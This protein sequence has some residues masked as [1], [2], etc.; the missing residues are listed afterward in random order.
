MLHALEVNDGQGKPEELKNRLGVA[1]GSNDTSTE[2][3]YYNKLGHLTLRGLLKYRY[4]ISNSVIL[5]KSHQVVAAYHL[6][7]LV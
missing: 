2:L 1:S 5:N 4:L 3:L 7:R 6:L